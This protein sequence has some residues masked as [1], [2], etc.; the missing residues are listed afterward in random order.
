[1][2][3][4]N[5]DVAVK[6][7]WQFKE[8]RYKKDRNDLNKQIERAQRLL[9]RN[10]PGRRAR[11]VK[12]AADKQS[13]ELNLDLKAKAEKLLGIKGYVTNISEQEMPDKEI[14]EY[15]HDLWHV[16]QAFRMTK[17]DRETRPIFHYKQEAIKA[18]VLI[19]FMGLMISKYLQLKTGLSVREI[20]SQLMQIHEAH[21]L[22]Q[23]TGKTHVMA[24][25]AQ[26]KL[27]PALME[28]LEPV[29]RH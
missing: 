1:M 9:E 7:V 3:K 18:H 28:A 24:M 17:S 16:E 6:I 15:Y 20:R 27:D 26:E 11:F 25:D 4:G 29:L 21:L 8:K 5:D 23:I 12:K 2:K 19:C 13:F 22:D 14:I 10:E